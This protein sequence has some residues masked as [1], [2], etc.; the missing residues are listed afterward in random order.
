MVIPVTGCPRCPYPNI[1]LI[2][3]LLARH[4]S[5]LGACFDLILSCQL[6]PYA[7]FRAESWRGSVAAY[8]GVMILLISSIRLVEIMLQCLSVTLFG[9][10]QGIVRRIEN[11]V[12]HSEIF[13]TC[14]SMV[15]DGNPNSRRTYAVVVDRI[16]LRSR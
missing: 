9:I 6:P 11:Y 5:G 2:D 13:F 15:L 16:L 7:H 1:R 10:I 3:V 4:L 8:C 14:S 12:I